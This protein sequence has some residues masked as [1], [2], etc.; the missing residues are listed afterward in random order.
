MDILLLII[1]IIETIIFAY[2]GFAAIYIFTYAFAGRLI[3]TKTFKPSAARRKFAV[4]IPGYKED[5]VIIDVAKQALKQIYPEDKYDVIVIADSF[6]KSTLEELKKLNIIL[7]E[8]S[9]EKSTKSKALNKAMAE[10][11]DDYDIALILDADNIMEHDVISKLNEAFDGGF[12]AIQAHRI[13][14]NTNT[15]FAILVSEALYKL[16]P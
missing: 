14:K 9:F 13:A 11:G 4:L 2:L 12:L 16:T 8:V 15:S 7:I 10:I 1:H 6:K 5:A 3:S